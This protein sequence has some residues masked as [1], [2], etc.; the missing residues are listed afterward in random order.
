MIYLFLA[1]GFETVEALCPLDLLR[2]AGADVKTV[3]VTGE[4]VTSRQGVTVKADLAIDEIFPSDLPEMLI[5]P[6]GIP[7]ADN[8][9]ASDK[10]NEMIL[11]GA[12][13]G[14]FLAAIC[15]APYILGRRGLLSGKKV[16]CFPE[17]IFIDR[18]EGAEYTEAGVVRDGNVITAKAMGVSADFGLVLIDALFGREKADEIAAAV[19]HG[20]R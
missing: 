12:R 2:R 1:D 5:L 20:Q 19:F 4:T 13:R 6:G 10:V 7:G 11:D 18:L 3:G 8:L 9:D 16:T 15:A 17:K 14:A